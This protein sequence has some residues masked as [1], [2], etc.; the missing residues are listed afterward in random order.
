MDKGGLFEL[1]L[2]HVMGSLNR[3]R[4]IQNT[5]YI[6]VIHANVL[7]MINREAVA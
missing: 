6:E 7:H 2:L 4:C 5:L 1:E 3:V